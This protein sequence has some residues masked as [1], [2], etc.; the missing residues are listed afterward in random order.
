MSEL[1][2]TVCVVTNVANQSQSLHVRFYFYVQDARPSKTHSSRTLY[3][4]CVCSST[5]RRVNSSLAKF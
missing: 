4:R 5:M 1:V 2:T 3:P